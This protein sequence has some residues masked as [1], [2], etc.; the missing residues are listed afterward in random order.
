MAHHTSLKNLPN[1]DFWVESLALL[2][3]QAGHGLQEVPRLH[4]AWAFLLHHYLR[5]KTPLLE[6]LG[7]EELW[8]LPLL[9]P[10]W[11]RGT[12]LHPPLFSALGLP[13]VSLAQSLEGWG[14]WERKFPV[15][16]VGNTDQFRKG[17]KEP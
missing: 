2:L 13:R 11:G 3:T 15:N 14:V 16:Q 7:G 5:L 12:K 10:D 8:L 6:K 17:R 1:N 9:L 4:C